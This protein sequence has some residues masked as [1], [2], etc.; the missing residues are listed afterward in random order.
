MHAKRV[1]IAL[2]FSV[3]LLG[4][5]PLARAQAFDGGAADAGPGAAPD[6][7][8]VTDLAPGADDAAPAADGPLDLGPVPG[9][10]GGGCGCAV[11]GRGPL[12][13]SPLAPFALILLALTRRR[14][15]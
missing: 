15:R 9:F 6:I 3:G 7:A 12:A 1:G 2:W 13:P 5:A 11:A 8:L 10:A 4:S 14:Q